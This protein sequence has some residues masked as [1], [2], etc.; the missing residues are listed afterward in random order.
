MPVVKGSSRLPSVLTVAD[1]GPGIAPEHLPHLFERFY[2]ADPARAHDGGAGLGLAIA[3]W[4]VTAHG[5]KS[6]FPAGLAAA[7]LS[8]CSSRGRSAG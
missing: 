5:G 7:R 3:Q 6:R 1:T 4:I 2:R 8:P